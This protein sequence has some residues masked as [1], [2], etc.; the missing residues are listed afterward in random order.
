M[1]HLVKVKETWL[2]ALNFPV[3]S[4]KQEHDEVFGMSCHSFA[5]GIIDIPAQL[6]MN[7]EHEHMRTR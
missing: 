4:P 2:G 6:L 3:S 1:L 5:K 7:R